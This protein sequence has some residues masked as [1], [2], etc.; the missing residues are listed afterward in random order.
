MELSIADIAN[1]MAQGQIELT[2][3]ATSPDDEGDTWTP[4]DLASAG[5]RWISD[6]GGNRQ[7]LR[8]GPGPTYTLP[9][10]SLTQFFRYAW[11]MTVLPRDPAPLPAVVDQA[12]LD[13]TGAGVGDTLARVRRSGSR[14][15]WT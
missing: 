15:R 10:E 13:R 9:V 8:V 7:P 12:F 3:V 4:I 14:S 11:S 2:G 5:G 6:Q 1:G